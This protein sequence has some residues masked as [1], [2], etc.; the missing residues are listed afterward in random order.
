MSSKALIIGGTIILILVLVG[1]YFLF[2]GSGQPQVSIASY[3][4]NDTERPKA[5]VKEMLKD[6]GEMKVSDEKTE[7]FTLKNAGKKP[8]QI[9]NVSSSCNCTFGILVIDGKESEEFGM[10]NVSDYVGAIAPGKE[11]IVKVIYRPFVM[12]VYGA[13]EREVYVTTNDPENQKLVFKVKAY[14]K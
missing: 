5:K 13:V 10:H 11:A 3:S 7:T 1:S 9:S 6:M 4:K 8:L 2:A 12:P 14:V